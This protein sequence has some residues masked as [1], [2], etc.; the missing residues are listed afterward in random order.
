MTAP[1]GPPGGAS[2]EPTRLL[3]IDGLRALA[4]LSVVAYHYTYRYDF[5]FLH[6]GPLPV[7]FPTGFMGVNLF[8]AISGFVIYMT[9]D[10]A[11][12]PLDFVVSRFTRL[13]PTYWAAVI[14][15]W[16]VVTWMGLSGYAVSWKA[17][18]VNLTMVQGLFHVPDVDG[19]YWSL[20]VELLFYVWMLAAWASGA[21][22]RPIVT[23]GV[24]VGIAA[25]AALGDLT[26]TV[27]FPDTVRHFLILAHIPWFGLGIAAYLSMKE[28]FKPGHAMLLAAC[29]AT[30][31]LSRRV[32]LSVG[33][34]ITA[35]AIFAASRG[36]LPF[37]AWKPLVFFGAISYPLYLVHEKIGWLLISSLEER[38]IAPG[39]AIMAAVGVSILLAWMLHELVETPASRRLREKYRQ[40]S[41]RA[42]GHPSRR[43]YWAI[44]ALAMLFC[45]AWSFRATAPVREPVRAPQLNVT[46]GAAVPCRA[47][48]GTRLVV[49]L[50]QSNAASHGEAPRGSPIE[51]FADGGCVAS[52]DPLPNTTGSGASLWTALPAAR[53]PSPVIV[54]PLAVENTRIGPWVTEGSELRGR[55]ERLLRRA[56]TSGIPVAAVLWQQG[57]A[58]AIDSTPAALYRDHLLA[59]RRLLTEHGISAPL[60]VAKS[61]RCRGREGA[62]IRRAIDAAAAAD[63][64]IRVGPD[65][66]R[67]DAGYRSAN[68]CHFNA[69]GREAAA[70]LWQA[71]LARL[72]DRR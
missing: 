33:G 26:G 18:L 29:F 28:G 57:E 49:V 21:L 7:S 3:Q 46:P 52:G 31:M 15:T 59:L 23:C 48:P 34:V 22:R 53:G 9:L 27:R 30:I 61:T 43:R 51:V 67:L 68:G 55:L 41:L 64:S 13:F 40:S 71:H 72:L 1:D 42:R 47:D 69:A 63:S 35:F 70:A 11:R 65:T 39:A 37:L 54:A 19:V 4:A 66:D 25:L 14:L 45:T 32:D 50:G 62:A 2:T 44:G 36:K 17:A 8:F 56:R 38:G 20:L 60:I 5:L 6:A 24:W 16:S 58:D 12:A 10:R